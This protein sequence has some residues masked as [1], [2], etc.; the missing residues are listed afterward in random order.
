MRGI[1][2]V[3]RTCRKF[4]RV[5]C[6]PQ[7][8]LGDGL[9]DRERVLD[10]VTEFIH[11][12]LLRLFVPFEL[13]DVAC[14]PKPFEDLAIL[15]KNRNGSRMGPP[16]RAVD[17]DDGMLK[18]KWASVADGFIDGGKNLLLVFRMD[19]YVSSQV[20]LGLSVSGMKSLPRRWRISLQLALMRYTTS[21]VAVTNARYR[22]SLPRKLSMA[23]PRTLAIFKCASTRANSS[24]A[25]KGFTK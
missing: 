16:Q 8:L 9:N 13:A 4:S 25:L 2:C 3:R 14:C 20:L 19:I 5:L 10:A 17:A 21:E 24:R 1:G 12:Q 6:L 11:Q 15:T 7:R 22:S 23:S 18:F